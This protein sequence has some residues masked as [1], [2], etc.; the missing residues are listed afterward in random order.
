M[1]IQNLADDLAAA[2]DRALN[3]PLRDNPLVKHVLSPLENYEAARAG[4]PYLPTGRP[5]H[6]KQQEVGVPA[7]LAGVDE[8]TLALADAMA[9]AARLAMYEP[10]TSP[11]LYQMEHA[12]R[13]YFLRGNA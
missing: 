5:G 12:R 7:V 10:P 13:A 3:A 8:K 11:S 9:R 6:A 1:T 4:R 2:I